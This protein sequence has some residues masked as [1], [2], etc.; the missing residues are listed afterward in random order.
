LFNSVLKL[1]KIANDNNDEKAKY[2]L[3]DLKDNKITSEEFL[4]KIGKI[5]IPEWII[6]LYKFAMFIHK[7]G[8][9][10]YPNHTTDQHESN[11]LYEKIRK[12][13]QI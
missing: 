1:W 12:E 11:L 2:L 13:C 5:P 7:M 9:I 4:Q 6:N 8:I 3:I 10:P